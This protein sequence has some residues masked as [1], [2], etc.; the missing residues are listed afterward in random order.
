MNHR[1]WNMVAVVWRVSKQF[2]RRR[3]TTDAAWFSYDSDGCGADG[4][5]ERER[6]PCRTRDGVGVEDVGAVGTDPSRRKS[7]AR[8]EPRWAARGWPCGTA[9]G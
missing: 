1:I 6:W 4:T 3:K 2:G 9:H 8:G 7:V 5:G